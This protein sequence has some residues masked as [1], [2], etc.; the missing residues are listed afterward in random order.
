MP[1]SDIVKKYFDRGFRLIFYQSKQKGPTGQEAI[2]WTERSDKIEDYKEGMNVGVFTGVEIQ[3]GRYLVD[4]DFDWADGLPLTKRILPP[5]QFGFGRLS[6]PISHAFYTSPEPL[7]SFSFDNIDGKPLVEL[8]GTKN[9]GG[10]G[11][12]TMIPP[13]IHPNGE[14]LTLKQDG[15][16]GHV[17]NLAR[18][19]SLYA[20]ACLVYSQFPNHQLLHDA[21]LSLAGFLLTDGGLD[22]QEATLILTACAE[23]SGNNIA[24]AEL[25][26]KSTASRLKGGEHVFG[27]TAF[28]KLI[29]DRGKEVVARIKEWLGGGDF[30]EDQKGKVI[31]DHQYNIKRAMDKLGMTLSFDQFSCKRMVEYV[32]P[33]LNGNSYKG[34]LID[35][36]M[37]QAWLQIDEKFHFRPTYGLYEKIVYTEAFS[38]KYHPVLDYLKPLVW[39]GI[40]R[41]D[42][43]LIQS[44]G[45]A[46]TDYVRAVSAIVLLA[47]VR[48]VTH[49][50][51]KYDEMLVLESLKQ[52][53]FK[54]TALRT[55][56]PDE[57]WFSDDLP[58]NVDSKQIVERTLGKWIIEASDLSGMRSSQ[59]EHLKGMLSRQSDGPVRMAY[60]HNPIEQPRQFIIIG[61]TNSTNYLSDST[62]NRRFWPIRIQEF[63]IDFIRKNREQLWAEALTREGKGESI[64]LDPS[65]YEMAAFQ[66]E[67]RRAEDP[68]ESKLDEIFTNDRNWRLTKDD[69]WNSLGIPID[70]RDPKSN[71]RILKAME[72]LGFR[73]MSVKPQ[74]K[75]GQG[76][77]I[78][79][80]KVAKGFARDVVKGQS[81]LNAEDQEEEKE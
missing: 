72:H 9:D 57:R 56:C 38:N 43:W 44:A 65:L 60:A 26:V 31:K 28:M 40:P 30:L 18:V 17:E 24:D 50:G 41:V 19:I 78:K 33:S 15:E 59:H 81:E 22:I 6:R 70:R 29:G 77:I 16:I 58:L 32:N 74:D 49:P 7:V 76:A 5:T 69:I 35:E 37:D 21:R 10:I 3:P 1:D 23:A 53:L 51:C 80:A 34:P 79:D 14:E 13:S 45:A 11:L 64:R 20:V 54:S 73:R 68:W 25:T 42:T 61:T 62:G 2:K 27:K 55:L 48:R 63:N 52:G 75:N 36:V 46:D 4:I 47:A 67:R 8:R 66:Q 71:D 39:D 12:Q